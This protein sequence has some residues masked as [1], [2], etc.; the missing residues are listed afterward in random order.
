MTRE[1]VDREMARE[2]MK[3]ARYADSKLSK[4]NLSTAAG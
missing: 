3:E 2:K 1:G 4:T